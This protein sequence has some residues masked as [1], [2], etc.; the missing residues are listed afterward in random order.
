MWIYHPKL[1]RR[2][3]VDFKGK[4]VRPTHFREFAERIPRAF[5]QNNRSVRCGRSKEGI[6][7][8]GNWGTAKEYLE[9]MEMNGMLK[10]VSTE[11]KPAF[12]VGCTPE[13]ELLALVQSIG[14]RIAARRYL[15]VK[16]IVEGSSLFLKSQPI[17]RLR[18]NRPFLRFA[19]EAVSQRFSK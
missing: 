9:I 8:V 1:R 7:G 3:W 11:P 10:P 17:V 6:G 5:R 12:I 4:D 15:R 13:E 18:E 2:V 14:S 16:T 19:L